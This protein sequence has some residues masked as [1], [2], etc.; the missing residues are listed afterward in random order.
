MGEVTLFSSRPVLQRALAEIHWPPTFSCPED[1]RCGPGWALRHLPHWASAQSPSFLRTGSITGC[2]PC[3]LHRRP[4]FSYHW[5]LGI[6]LV[7]ACCARP[8]L[9]RSAF[10]RLPLT[11]ALCAGAVT[12][13][14]HTS[15]LVCPQ[16]SVILHAVPRRVQ[17]LLT[18]GVTWYTPHSGNLL[19]QV[20][21]WM[22]FLRFFKSPLTFQ[23]LRQSPVTGPSHPIIW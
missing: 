11:F 16:D 14:K 8:P 18:A 9:R 23:F 21:A 10:P 17:L 7:W 19:P 4:F 22:L 15:S 3:C 12:A 5:S 2:F 6:T 1:G 13:H 20:F